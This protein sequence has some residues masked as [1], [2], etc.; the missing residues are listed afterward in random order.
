M[1]SIVY[2][3]AALGAFVPVAISLAWMLWGAQ[4]GFG[5]AWSNVLLLTIIAWPSALMFI[6]TN[7]ISP[8]T[9]C[10][11]VVLNVVLYAVLGLLAHFVWRWLRSA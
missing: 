3:A 8:L 6:D 7:G 2:W 1:P 4:L 10:L 9:L 11:S 5:S